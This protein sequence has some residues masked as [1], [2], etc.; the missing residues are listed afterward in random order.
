VD[1]GQVSVYTS[2]YSA[3]VAY[4]T[5]CDVDW[6]AGTISGANTYADLSALPIASQGWQKVF[7]QWKEKGLI[8]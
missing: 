8:A 1:E 5:V 6:L 4:E 3:E 2:Q 7:D